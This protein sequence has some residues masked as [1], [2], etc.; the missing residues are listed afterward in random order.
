M[1]FPLENIIGRVNRERRL[2]VWSLILTFFGDAILPRGGIVSAGTVSKLMKE[3]G[4]EDGT[5][6]TAFSRLAKDDWIIRNKQGRNAYYT[7]APKGHKPFQQASNRI[8]S[9][10][11]QHTKASSDWL[12]AINN[13]IALDEFKLLVQQ[14]N[15]LLLNTS[16]G[17][18]SSALA[19]VEEQLHKTQCMVAKGSSQ[20]VPDWVKEHESLQQYAVELSDFLG[21]FS[22]L[23]NSSEITTNPINAMAARCLLIHEWRRLILRLPDIPNVLLPDDWP[24]QAAGEMVAAQYSDLFAASENWLDK[25]FLESFGDTKSQT[26]INSRFNML[27][28]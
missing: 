24:A 9:I 11:Q 14:Y 3:F 15:G 27:Q 25:E 8:Y 26:N 2:R 23:T 6:R 20:E 21:T 22:G 5:V 10:P 18:F 19:G 1:E 16:T 28:N 13:S 7:L 17:V 4:I 12:L